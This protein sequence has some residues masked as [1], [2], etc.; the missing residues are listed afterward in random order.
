MGLEAGNDTIGKVAARGKKRG[1]EAAVA[2]SIM[3]PADPNV[4]ECERRFVLRKFLTNTALTTQ[5]IELVSDILPPQARR[6]VHINTAFA[7]PDVARLREVARGGCVTFYASRLIAFLAAQSAVRERLFRFAEDA[8][9]WR[10]EGG[11][12]GGGGG[13][14]SGGH[15]VDAG[16]GGRCGG[17][18]GRDSSTSKG[19]MLPLKMPT[20]TSMGGLLGVGGSGGDGGDGGKD[21]CGVEALGRDHVAAA[22]RRIGLGRS[23][24]RMQTHSAVKE[25]ESARRAEQQAAEEDAATAGNEGNERRR[26]SPGSTSSPAGASSPVTA[27]TAVWTNVKT[28]C[29]IARETNVIL[30]VLCLDRRLQVREVTP[31]DCCCTRVVYL[32]R[33]WYTRVYSCILVTTTCYYPHVPHMY[34]TCCREWFPSIPC[35]RYQRSRRP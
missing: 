5:G 9:Q 35:Y 20:A 7:H 14:G 31:Y 8:R 3:C 29:L 30:C 17:G 11:G 15:F 13:G 34:P 19:G 1:K 24:D 32:C 10:R 4:E 27:V 28:L 21:E 18:G 6:L 26:L 25:K 33:R 12:S 22:L 2:S 16:F 23:A